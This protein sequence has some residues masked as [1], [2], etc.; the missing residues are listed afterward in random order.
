MLCYRKHNTQR[1]SCSCGPITTLQHVALTC[2]P[3]HCPSTQLIKR[4]LLSAG[5]D[6]GQGCSSRGCFGCSCCATENYEKTAS[7][8]APINDGC[9]SARLTSRTQLRQVS[10]LLQGPAALAAAAAVPRIACCCCCSQSSPGST[11]PCVALLLLLRVA[12]GLVGRVGR[13]I[14]PPASQ[15]THREQARSD[16]ATCA[17]AMD[18]DGS[19]QGG[20]DCASGHAPWQPHVRTYYLSAPAGPAWPRE[21][22]CRRQALRG[23]RATRML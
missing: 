13:C 4:R 12:V 20:P 18:D 9:C 22:V 14:R 11:G 2:R 6:Q 3:L 7:A 19:S 8:L 16:R 5:A 1:H 23:G 21:A 10:L 15:Q 17:R